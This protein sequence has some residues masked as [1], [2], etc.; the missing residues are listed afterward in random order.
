MSIRSAVQKMQELDNAVGRFD[1]KYCKEVIAILRVY[2][3][4][5]FQDPL[6]THV[7][8]DLVED[9]FLLRFDPASQRL[10][11]IEIYNA[12]LLKIY[13]NTNTFWCEAAAV[14]GLSD[15]ERTQFARR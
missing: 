13:Y 7:L 6:A 9:G 1:L 2:L 3:S 5:A 15:R 4:C 10:L 14:V 8:L 12:S 11:S